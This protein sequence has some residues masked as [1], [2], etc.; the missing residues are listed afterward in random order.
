MPPQGLQKAMTD[1][2]RRDLDVVVNKD[3][4]QEYGQLLKAD[5]SFR[6]MIRLKA[7]VAWKIESSVSLRS[8]NQ[9]N[10][11]QHVLPRT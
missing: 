8:P 5:G 1:F 2:V 7:I 9:V 10:R 4:Y 3:T 6:G 11:P